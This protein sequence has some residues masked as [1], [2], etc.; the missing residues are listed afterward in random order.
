[1]VTVDDAGGAHWVLVQYMGVR[2]PGDL[3]GG[4]CTG[5]HDLDLLGE[6]F[7]FA[8]VVQEPLCVD[9]QEDDDRGH[10]GSGEVG[11]GADRAV[12]AEV[13]DPPAAAAQGYPKR[14]QP[15]F[16]LF[17]WYAGENGGRAPALAP[18]LG[19]SEEASSNQVGGE[20]LLGDRDLAGRPPFPEPVQVRKDDL[21][22]DRL[23]GVGS[24]ELVKGGVGGLLIQPGPVPR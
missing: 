22:Q 15:E 4:A 20:V 21:L 3:G 23:D 24:Q 10:E 18:A 12:G 1:M 11:D 16:V 17:A 19:K 8:R 13:G 7:D 6:V 14:Q 9:A 5:D 2:L